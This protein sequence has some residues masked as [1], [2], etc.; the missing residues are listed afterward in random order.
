MNN[1]GLWDDKSNIM[2]RVV[3]DRVYHEGTYK[4]V[5][6]LGANELDS[7]T[8][9]ILRVHGDNLTNSICKPDGVE[10]YKARIVFDEIPTEAVR[11]TWRYKLRKWFRI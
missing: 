11:K 8:R 1:L 4:Q 10:E 2:Q 6:S 3:Q 5:K 7:L 9:A